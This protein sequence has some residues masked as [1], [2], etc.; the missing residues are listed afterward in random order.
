MFFHLSLSHAYLQLDVHSSYFYSSTD[1]LDSF[2]DLPFY[3]SSEEKLFQ[4]LSDLE[5]LPFFCFP[6]E[7][8]FLQDFIQ[9]PL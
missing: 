8:P 1:L 2:K 7:F 5:E 3:D 9:T 4:T 6:E